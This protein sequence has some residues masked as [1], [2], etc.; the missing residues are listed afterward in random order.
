MSTTQQLGYA[1]GVAITGIVYFA[2]GF[3]TSLIQLA[4]VAA[5]V[6]VA[7]LAL[8]VAAKR[9]GVPEPVVVSLG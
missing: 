4:G 3:E 7:A 2:D 9:A 1:L 8:P 5:G 6:V